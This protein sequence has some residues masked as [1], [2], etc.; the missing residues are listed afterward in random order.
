[1]KEVDPYDTKHWQ[2]ILAYMRQTGRLFDKMVDRVARLY[3][4]LPTDVPFDINNYPGLKKGIEQELRRLANQIQEGVTNGI[5][6]EWALS[7]NKNDKVVESIMKGRRL[8]Q[9]LDEKWMGRNMA[10]LTS[11]K[12]RTDAG[13]GLS[14]RVWNIVKG[15]AVG[16][17]R[18]MALG[19]YNGTPAKELAEGMKKYLRN[20]Q[21]FFT[22]FA[23]KRG[24]LRLSTAARELKPGRGVYRSPFK[25]AL[26]LTRTETNRAYQKADNERWKQQDFVLGVEVQRSNVPYD[27]DI[28]EA[29]VGHYPKGYQWD[30]F[31]PNCFIDPQTPIYTSRG[32]VPIGKVKIGDMVLTHEKR[33]RRVYALPRTPQQK[34]NVVRLKLKGEK[35]ISMTENHLVLIDKGDH[36]HWIAAGDVKEGYNVVMLAGNHSGEYNLTGWPVESITRFVPKKNKTLYN[37]S[38]E[39]DE[40][41]IAKGVVVHNCRCRAIP[42]LADDD[43]IINAIEAEFEGRDYQFTGQVEDIPETFKEFKNKTNY[44]HFG[45]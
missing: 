30:L 19:I 33:F 8:P 31:H 38:V 42:L 36:K 25:N 21:E 15:Q 32:W 26:R 3:A 35:F 24:Q 40:S 22:E 23:E 5:N 14:G 39:K 2:N 10:A 6:N 41:Y 12:K 17:E 44:E 18:H 20:P 34:P 4:Q 43:D 27:C 1:M 29:G 28:C 9:S 13:L 16:V 37:L 45:H 7:N 11:F